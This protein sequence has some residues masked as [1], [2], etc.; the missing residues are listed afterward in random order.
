MSR[1][2]DDLILWSPR[3]LGILVCVFLSMFALDAF[4]PGRTAIQALPDFALHVAPMLILL[5]VVG[6]SFRWA[7]VG[8]LGFTLLAAAYAYVARAHVSWIMAVAVPLL[9]VGLLFF[10]S[11]RHRMRLGT[12]REG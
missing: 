11:W 9:L 12:E 10:V 4:G 7:W 2:I 6:V 5:V 3:V 1:Q 8:G